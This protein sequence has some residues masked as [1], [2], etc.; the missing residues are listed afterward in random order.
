MA[1]IKLEQIE[2]FE[3][4]AKYTITSS[5]AMTKI[6]YSLDNQN[7]WNTLF[8]NINMLTYTHPFSNLNPNTLYKCAFRLT[9][10]AKDASGKDV[11]TIVP[12]SFQTKEVAIIEDIVESWAINNLMLIK[13]HNPENLGLSI[14]LR[15]K[16]SE[17]ITRNRDQ[18]IL[19][20][21]GFY[22][23]ELTETERTKI[24]NIIKNNLNKNPKLDIILRSYRNTATP[25]HTDTKTVN[26]IL[27]YIYWLKVNGEWKKARLF[28]RVN[29]GWKQSKFW[30]KNTDGIWNK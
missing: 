15:Y 2:L 13:I 19:D 28:G 9:L 16:T 11:I 1:E 21:N 27:N 29:S 3:T 8:N 7:T 24:Y 20:E 10:N 30:F 17:F 25:V 22:K 4:S 18:V 12:F 5:I 23:L 26:V 6:E 14:T